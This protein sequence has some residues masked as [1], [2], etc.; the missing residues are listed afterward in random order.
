[1]KFFKNYIDLPNYLLRFTLLQTKRLHIR[2]HTILAADGTPYLH[3]HPFNYI[4]VIISGGYTEQFLDNK[5]LKT[6]IH[7]RF[8]FIKRKNTDF[9]R[10]L[11]VESKTKTLFFAFNKEN[12]WELKKRDDIQIPKHFK[13]PKKQGIYLRLIKNYHVYAK[14][15]NFWYKGANTPEEAEKESNLSIHQVGKFDTKFYTPLSKLSTK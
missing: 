1:M 13:T 2:L 9:H 10:I 4:S 12:N 7:K 5:N 14:F 8:S 15:D 11:S 3:N 6:I